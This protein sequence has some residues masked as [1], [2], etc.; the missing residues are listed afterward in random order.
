MQ[1]SLL[2][3]LSIVCMVM[4]GLISVS[5]LVIILAKWLDK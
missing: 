2:T 4:A 5:L 3:A 1:E